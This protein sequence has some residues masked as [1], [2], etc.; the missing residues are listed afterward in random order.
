MS[1][2]EQLKRRNV[3]RIAAAY[4]AVSWLL[5]QIAETLL[6]VFGFGNGPIRILVIVLAIGFLPALILSWLFELTPEGIKRDEEV[7][8]SQPAS[9]ATRERL[10]QVEAETEIYRRCH[11]KWRKHGA[12]AVN[13]C[14][15]HAA[16]YYR[17]KGEFRD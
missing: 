3:I 17:D 13:N 11:S 2:F 1:L 12:R 9:I 7:D 5:V 8:H 4:L 6:P 16:N 15:I 10:N 14:A